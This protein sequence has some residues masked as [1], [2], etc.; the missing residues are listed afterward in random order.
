MAGTVAANH[1]QG[2]TMGSSAVDMK[3]RTLG[4][5][6]SKANHAGA[7]VEDRHSS[8]TVAQMSSSF[9]P[10][11][12]VTFDLDNTLWC[13]AST[14]GAAIAAVN[15]FWSRQSIE[16]TVRVEVVMKELFANN[17]A[18][19][20]PLQGEQATCPCQLTSLRLDAMQ[21]MLTTHHNFSPQEA[22]DLAEQAFQIMSQTRHDA[23]PQ[24]MA[25]NVV[26]TLQALRQNNPQIVIGAITDGNANPGRVDSLAPFFDFCIQAEN[27]GV[28]K[29]DSRIFDH[30]IKLVQQLLLS[31]SRDEIDVSTDL[32]T[33]LKS[34]VHIG[35]DLAKD[36]VGAKRVGMRTIWSRE[37]ILPSLSDKPC[38]ALTSRDL[39]S[40]GTGKR[41]TKPN[42]DAPS[43]DEH[44]CADAIVDRFADILLVLE[45]WHKKDSQKQ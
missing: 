5:S 33:L 30:A 36:I 15:E 28:G 43:T 16:S 9:S 4:T 26:E 35:D 29:P 40:W 22:A 18:K 32:G 44:A 23:I 25:A 12:V 13:T 27:I 41:D 14:I 45:N 24:Y 20:A 19:Y 2:Q 3:N 31:P 1:Q 42:K 17:K 6:N 8:A 10:I 11:R 39:S 21:H 37:L 34:W 7:P 38:S